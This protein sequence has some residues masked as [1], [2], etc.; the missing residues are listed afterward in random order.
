MNA[1]KTIMK[2]EKVDTAARESCPLY[3]DK[4]DEEHTEAMSTCINQPKWQEAQKF[5]A[6]WQKHQSRESGEKSGYYHKMHW[7]KHSADKFSDPRPPDSILT[8]WGKNM[9]EALV[10]QEKL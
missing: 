7:S 6:S 5:S 1:L 8:F 3:I 10:C 4:W 9:E 2:L